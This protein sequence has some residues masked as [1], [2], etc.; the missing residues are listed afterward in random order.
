MVCTTRRRISPSQRVLEMTCIACKAPSRL[1]ARCQGRN[2]PRPWHR[3]RSGPA[4]T[5][6]PRLS[7]S[8]SM[9][10]RA[11]GSSRMAGAGVQAASPH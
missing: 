4:Y 10:S 11:K 1:R 7:A 3:T 8:F 6:S 9:T 2:D 5:M